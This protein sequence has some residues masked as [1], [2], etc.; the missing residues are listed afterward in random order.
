MC[1]GYFWASS[2]TSCLF[3]VDSAHWVLDFSRQYSLFYLILLVGGCLV[4]R[5]PRWDYLRELSVLNSNPSRLVV[6]TSIFWPNHTGIQYL[7]TAF[8]AQLW[9]GSEENLD[10]FPE[11]S[12]SCLVNTN[13]VQEKGS[14]GH[15]L[16]V[17]SFRWPYNSSQLSKFHVVPF[18]LHF[19]GL[20]E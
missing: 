11:F 3:P 7:F 17:S 4:R 5:I 2:K 20:A 15:V 10:S 12:G 6:L 9:F 18:P 16:P 1:K 19:L 13:L 8:C 14:H